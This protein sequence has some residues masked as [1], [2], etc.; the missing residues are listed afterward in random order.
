M[1]AAWNAYTAAKEGASIR[2]KNIS[3][4]DK[5]GSTH[6]AYVNQ[7]GIAKPFA[8]LTD[9]SATLEKQ[10]CGIGST[11]VLQDRSWSTIVYPKGTNMVSGATC[12]YENSYITSAFPTDL[13][14]MAHLGKVGYVDVDNIYHPITP[15]YLNSYSTNS[16]HFFGTTMSSCI[17]GATLKFGD[18]IYIRYTDK[19]AKVNNSNV[20][21]TSDSIGTTFYIQNPSSTT[22]T[23]NVTY[24][25]NFILSTDKDG[26]KPSVVINSNILQV[27]TTS[28]L[29]G[30]TFTFIKS[31]DI[32]NTSVVTYGDTLMINEMSNSKPVVAPTTSDQTAFYVGTTAST[33]SIIHPV[34]GPSCDI[35]TLK[36]GCTSSPDCLGFVHSDSDNKWQMMTLNNV[37]TKDLDRSSNIYLRD[38]SFNMSNNINCPV[39]NTIQ[40]IPSSEMSFPYGAEL[41]SGCPYVPKLN[42]PAYDN[43]VTE[44]NTKWSSLS[45]PSNDDLSANRIKL[46]GAT[47]AVKT[48]WNN[49]NT[50]FD[51]V[52]EK[53]D[54]TRDVD[55]TLEQRITDS[56]VLDEHHKA[57]AILWGI[58]SVSLIS[59]IIFRP[60]N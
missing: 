17:R 36:N 34:F 55:V 8:S 29:A 33:F 40:A 42:V 39:N 49:Y 51:S 38:L 15:T 3:F 6:Y 35:Q 18:S 43:Y 28:T 27:D 14:G 5:E 46:E 50:A 53:H 20:E 54:S 7:F 48:A 26:P 56:L 10:S 45:V 44:F 2:S 4:L 22:S 30:A 60:N 59:I 58:I 52:W 57:L 23:S 13:S 19:Y 21:P 24:G 37:Y 25:T 11:V 16:S 32:L 31:G 1:E 12:G 41:T 9:Y 47:V